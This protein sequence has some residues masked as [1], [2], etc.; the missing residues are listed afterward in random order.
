MKEKNHLNKNDIRLIIEILA[1]KIDKPK[2]L[3]ENDL[4]IKRIFTSIKLLI[5]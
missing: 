1:K 4:K 3:L 5:R 2:S